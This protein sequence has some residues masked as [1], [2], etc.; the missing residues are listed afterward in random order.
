MDAT[1]VAASP[2][3]D[4]GTTTIIL[5]EGTRLQKLQRFRALKALIRDMR[6]EYEQLE[7]ELFGQAAL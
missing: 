4:F 7:R 5:I 2:E 3:A 6:A 1:P